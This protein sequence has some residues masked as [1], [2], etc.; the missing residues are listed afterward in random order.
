MQFASKKI[1]TLPPYLFS[2][3]H[4]KKKE[5][6]QRGV[7]II[8]LGIGSPDL[9]TPQFIVDR[10]IEEAKNPSNHRYSPYEGCQEFKE[11]VQYYYKKRYDVNLDPDSE[12]LALIGSKEGIANFIQAVIDPNDG[13]LVP[14]PGYPVYRSAV[15]L[16]RGTVIDLPL[17]EQNGFKP[18]YQKITEEQKET[19]KLMILNYPSNPTTATANLNLFKEAIEFGKVH[20]IFIAHDNAYDLVTFGNYRSPSILQVPKAKEIAVEFG[21]LSKSF[22]MTGWRIGYVVGNPDLIR[23]LSILKSH[24]DTSQ[25]LPIQKAA[26]T[27]LTSDLSAVFENN[28]IFEKR[29]KKMYEIFTKKGLQIQKPKGTIF[30]WAKIPPPFTSVSFAAK[31]LDQRGI[32]VTPGTAFGKRGEGYVRISLSVNEK[33][34]EQ[35]EK[36]LE[37]WDP[38]EVG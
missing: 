37:K 3:F 12:I 32:V 9:P 2:Q 35:I 38:F 22:N 26:A 34:I 19:G 24:V 6:E 17:D 20:G 1:G 29:M 8:D 16:A 11:A 30:L 15:H 7:E 31:L 10:M 23:S 18:M 4:Q 13:V 5:L 21:S 36:R 25:F 28:R 14:D 33:S 27:A